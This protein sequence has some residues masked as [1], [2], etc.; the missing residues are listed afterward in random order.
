MGEYGLTIDMNS[1]V[2]RRLRDDAEIL[3]QAL[4]RRLETRRGSDWTDPDYGLLVDDYL[5][6]GLTPEAIE[7]AAG[8]I[9]A[10]VEKDER[11]RSAAV[12]PKVT[13]LSDGSVELAPEIVVFPRQ[14]EPFDFVGPIYNFTG[15]KLRKAA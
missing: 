5:G 8:E 10:E 3:K 14:G 6:D 13:V 15:G 4:Q 11:V 9:K 7:R 1:P 2:F 12:T